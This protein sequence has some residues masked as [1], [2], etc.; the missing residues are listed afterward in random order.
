MCPVPEK[1]SK[2]S[3]IH[4]SSNIT[5]SALSLVGEMMLSVFLKFTAQQYIYNNSTTSMTST[6]RTSNSLSISNSTLDISVVNHEVVSEVRTRNRRQSVGDG[7]PAS[8]DRTQNSMVPERLNNISKFFAVDSR[9]ET[10]NSSVK[11]ESLNEEVFKLLQSADNKTF[12]VNRTVTNMSNSES[13]ILSKT[14]KSVYNSRNS[15]EVVV[16]RYGQGA[17]EHSTSDRSKR[18][19]EIQ[20]T[21]TNTTTT[22]EESF[23]LVHPT[24]MHPEYIVFTWVLCL[25]ALATSLKLY[26]LVKTALAFGMV[27]VFSILI[28]I[29]Y[30][31]VFQITNGNSL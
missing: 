11:I 15:N 20:V 18:D 25:V 17:N 12:V 27:T 28:L 21:T 5:A 14:L 19:A 7:E 23:S 8:D 2:K 3:A 22:D 13:V 31:D 6:N 1:L 9:R 29:A 24:C 16:N 4:E 26:Y 10:S 30:R